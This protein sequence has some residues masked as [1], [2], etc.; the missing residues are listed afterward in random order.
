MLEQGERETTALL[1][2]VLGGI[3]AL[4]EGFALFDAEDRL[5]LCNERFRRGYPGV[6]EMLVPGVPWPLFLAEAGRRGMARGLDSLDAHLGAGN[7][8]PLTV[9]AAR[10]GGTFC[11]AQ[12]A[13]GQRWRLRADRDR[14]H[15]PA[16]GR[17]VARQ[18]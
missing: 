13:S 6:A 3:E 12:A 4:S 15:R 16:R 8:A 11:P 2:R 14:H 7:E 17:G 10:P 18:R 1:R 5:V 9:E